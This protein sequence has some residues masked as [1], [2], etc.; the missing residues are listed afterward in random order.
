MGDAPGWPMYELLGD[1]ALRH[2]VTWESVASDL[3]VHALYVETW[4][5]A[6]E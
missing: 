6:G 1:K 2:I 5:G 3:V 4:L